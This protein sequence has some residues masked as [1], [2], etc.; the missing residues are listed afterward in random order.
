[1]WMGQPAD[2][3]FLDGLGRAQDPRA[4]CDLGDQLVRS[5]GSRARKGRQLLGAFLEVSRLIRSLSQ[6]LAKNILA[7]LGD[8]SKV[9]GHDSSV[10]RT[11]L[12]RLEVMLIA[13]PRRPPD[14][15]TSTRRTGLRVAR[16]SALASL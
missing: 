12:A 11:L 6:V 15:S 10:S 4:G 1:M 9:T 13:F 2:M 16:I 14:S 7:Q 8:E 3:R 5:D